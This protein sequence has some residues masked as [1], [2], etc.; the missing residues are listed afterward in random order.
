MASTVSLDSLKSTLAQKQAEEGKPTFEA[1]AVEA[2]LDGGS[3]SITA[4]PRVFS[5]GGLGWYAGEDMVINGV[6]C[7]V[8]L[9]ISIKGTKPPKDSNT[10]L[11]K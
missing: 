3:G 1:P 5:S 9:T 2:V 10:K 11:S 4:Q 8:Q 7:R 6:P